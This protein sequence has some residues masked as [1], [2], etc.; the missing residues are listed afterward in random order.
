M[1]DELNL[2]NI[3]PLTGRE[4][5]VLQLLAEGQSNK[6]IADALF[7]EVSTV[8]WFNAQIYSK[9]DVKN[10]KQA[11]IRA[12]TIGLLDVDENDPLQAPLHNLP[13]DTIPFIGRSREI[14][15]LLEQLRDETIRLVTILGP[16]GM[17]KTRLSIEVGRGLLAYFRN[18]VYFV[19]LAPIISREQIVTTIADSIGFKFRSDIQAEHQLMAHL[20]K[21]EMLLIIDNFEHL[22]S[23][24][25]LLSG[26]LKTAPGVKI[27]VTSREKLALAGE[28]VYGISG[29]SFSIEEADD[30][31]NT[32]HRNGEA[33][34]C[35][36]E[37]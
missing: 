12:R 4:S 32:L 16:G 15:D 18:G 7:I 33:H 8:K 26:I 27:L 23:D 29:L 31:V 5:E 22:V 37:R 21:L 28:L 36:G 3:D 9:L 34:I 13:A 1:S 10:R 30:A 11:V 17:G 19:S 20:E 6:E 2:Y 35:T 25:E 24:A 14:R